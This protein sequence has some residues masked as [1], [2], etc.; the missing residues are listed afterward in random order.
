MTTATICLLAVLLDTWLGEPKRFHPL[1]GFGRLA[2][3]MEGSLYGRREQERKWRG[4]MAMALLVLP[5]SLLAGIA[6]MLP[7][8]GMLVEVLL[9]YLGIGASS[10]A[11]HGRKVAVALARHDLPAARH[12]V[13][14]MVSRETDA[15][16]EPAVARAAVESVLENGNDAIFGTLFWYVVLGAPGVVLYRLVNTLD[17]MW[18]YRNE[19]YGGFGWAAARLDDLL[20]WLPARLTALGYALLGETKRALRC[21]R[22][23]GRTMESPNAGAVMASGAGALGLLLGGPAVY[24]G[25]LKEKPQLGSGRPP[26][27]SDIERALQ[28]VQQT[29]WL[30]LGLIWVGGVFIWLAV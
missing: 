10:L 24:H 16:D 14:W 9:L 30:W 23:Q 13:S 17:A 11:Q 12:S 4:A 26:A 2:Y 1:A 28:L 25:R 6:A 3:W 21:W 19:H 27:A 29:T 15:M 18:G 5:L 8:V 22:V 7:Q 20:N